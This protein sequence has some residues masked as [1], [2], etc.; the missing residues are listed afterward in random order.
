M[1]ER[2][3]FS[4]SKMLAVGVQVKLGDCILILRAEWDVLL[5]T[6][7]SVVLVGV[8][9]SRDSKLSRPNFRDG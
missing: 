9:L 2:R 7:W 3:F 8:P 5:V 6:G 1:F 4:A